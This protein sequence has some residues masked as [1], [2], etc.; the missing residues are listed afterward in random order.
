MASGSLRGDSRGVIVFGSPVAVGHVRPLMPLA[1][2]FVERGYKV[3]WAI[4]GDDNEPA[5]AWRTPI[6]NLGV[7]FVD[8]DQTVKFKRGSTAEFSVPSMSGVFGRVLA[9]ANDVSEGAATAINTAAAGR[10]I[11]CGI[12]DYFAVWSYVAMRRLGIANIDVVVSAFPAMIDG[13]AAGYEDNPIY[14]RELAV[15]ASG[16]FGSFNTPL[17]CGMIPQDPGVRVLNFSSPRLCPD[18]PPGVHVLGVQRDALPHREDMASAPTEHQALARRLELARSGGARVVL[19]SMGTVVTRMFKRM[20]TTHSSFLKGLYTTVAASALRSGAVVVAST[21]DASASELGVDEATL[22]PAAHGRVF[23]MQFVP[24]P[25]LF[26]HGLIDV[27]LMHGG[28][29]TFH[30]AVVSA[31]PLLICPGFGDQEYVATAAD[32]LGVGV[33]IESLT[34][35]HLA[36]AVPLQRA[37]DELL[38]EMLAPGISRWK[39][40]AT[41]LAAHIKAENGLDAA[42]T[43]VLARSQ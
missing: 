9:R 6:S 28:A 1:K 29:N 33:A 22:G 31:I 12:Y 35:P 23:T 42:E 32:R 7:Q 43:L 8:V 13:M 5:S 11:V 37:A 41:A 19:L 15:L 26:A 27:M 17:R 16:A 36:G 39:S 2:R 21:C 34:V 20:G 30:E 14:R 25:F 18:V 4:S 24:Q 40:A 38:P 3:I 10:P